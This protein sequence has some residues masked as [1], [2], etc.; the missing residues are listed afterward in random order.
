M[1]G[2]KVN[3]PAIMFGGRQVTPDEMDQYY[4][5]QIVMPGTSHNFV[6]TAAPGSLAATPVFGAVNAIPD[7]PRNLSLII[8]GNGTNTSVGGTAVVNGLDQFGSVITET[9]SFAGSTGNGN[10]DGTKVFARFTSGTVTLGTMAQAGT[11]YLGFVT[12]TNC[13]FG[14]PVKIAGTGDVVL[15][16]HNAGTG[17]VSVGGGTVGAFVNAGMHAVRPAAALTGTEAITVWITSNYN[18]TNIAEVSAL[19]QK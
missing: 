8:R 14:L 2:I 6:G 1:A 18:P 10:A 7:Y 17:A 5:Y 19:R 13:L 9:L 12:G 11:S 15:L 4:V 16:S 3:E